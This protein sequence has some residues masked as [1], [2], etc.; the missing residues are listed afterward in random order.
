MGRTL[1]GILIQVHWH[2]SY[3]LVSRVH[4]RV[5]LNDKVISTSNAALDQRVSRIVI[6][7][8]VIGIYVL[9]C[10][11]PDTWLVTFLVEPSN[12]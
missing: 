9:I 4:G 1:G 5:I 7:S 8:G 3:L 2:N 6:C 11:Y 10:V 12:G